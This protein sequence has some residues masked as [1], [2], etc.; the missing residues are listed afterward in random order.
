M[1][2]PQINSK[3]VHRTTTGFC[4]YI[5][6][7]LDGSVPVERTTAGNPFVYPN[8]EVAER[9]IAEDVMD[10][11]LEFLAGERD[12]EDAITI[13]EYVVEIDVLPDGSTVDK[14][15]SHFGKDSW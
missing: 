9:Q 7:L 15:G 3:V 2:L 5:D 1:D 14:S 6:T 13:E 11:I 10:R 8:R 4:I 12:F